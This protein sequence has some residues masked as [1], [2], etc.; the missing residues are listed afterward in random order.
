MVFSNNKVQFETIPPLQ[1]VY[2]GEYSTAEHRDHQA[3][4][5]K[6]AKCINQN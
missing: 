6:Q 3:R 5:K 2:P 4:E 1:K